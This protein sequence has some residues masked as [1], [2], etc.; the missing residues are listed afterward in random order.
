[1][2]D[3]VTQLRRVE[4]LPDVGPILARMEVYVR[5]LEESGAHPD[6]VRRLERARERARLA[7]AKLQ[8]AETVMFK[9]LERFG[10]K[11]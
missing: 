6:V 4:G 7:A 11:K 10:A 8:T 1:L 9:T 2:I 3:Q 5:Q